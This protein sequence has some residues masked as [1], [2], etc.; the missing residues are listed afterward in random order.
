MLPNGF[1]GIYPAIISPHRA[2]GAFDVDAFERLIERFYGAGVHGLYVCGNTGEGYVMSAENRK[3]AVETA[4][5]CSKDRGKV[6]AHVGAPAEGDAVALAA[7]AAAAGVDGISSLPPYVQGYRFEE[8]LAYYQSVAGASDGR[9]V[10]VY[11]IPA[12]THREFSLPEVDRLLEIEG[13]VGLKFTN[14]NLYLMDG[15]LHSAHAPHVFNGHDEILLAGLTMGAQGGIGGI[16]NLAPKEF[17]GIYNAVKAGDMTTGLKLQSQV[18]RLIRALLAHG[19]IPAI[20][21]VLRWQGIDCG[22]PLPP[23]RPLDEVTKGRL[24][25]DID[26]ADTGVLE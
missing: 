21:E 6:I 9:P 8:I 26:A 13:V 12:V 22:D 3:L 15:I 17:T 10:F 1:E 4:V 24:R 16:Y 18:N 23:M 20:R 14:H 11:Y 25:Q 7:H 5:R 2:D 19:L